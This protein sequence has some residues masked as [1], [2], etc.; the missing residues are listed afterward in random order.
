MK[1]K[2]PISA[3]D[4]NFQF[5][6]RPWIQFDSHERWMLGNLGPSVYN[7]QFTDDYIINGDIKYGLHY[8]DSEGNFLQTIESNDF[9]KDFD[10][11]RGTT[12]FAVSDLKGFYGRITTLGNYCLYG[13]RENNQ[14]ML[15]LYDLDR[16]E[17]MMTRPFQEGRA[18]MLDNSAMANYVYEPV[19]TTDNLLFT[20]DLKG[21]TLCRFPNYNPVPVMRGNAYNSPPPP[22][23]YYYAKQ[24]TIRQTLNDTVYRVIHP[25]RLLPAYVLNFGAYGTD[26]QTYF[27]G[28]LTEK[29][30]PFTWK[31]S[32]RY[33]L[34]VY[35]QNRDTPNNRRDG[36]VKFFYSYYDKKNRQLYHF[37]EDSNAPPDNEFLIENPLP[38]ALPFLLAYT[39]MEDNQL[40]VVFSKKRLEEI[41]KNKRFASLPPEQQNKLKALQNELDDGEVLI[42]ILE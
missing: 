2:H 26:V 40:R 25:N 32:E 34:I 42:M 17:R 16:N 12:S 36:S 38:D 1:L 35:T 3:T 6:W 20:L 41:V 8:F 29:L 37:N 11:A 27:G 19:N 33:I 39:D 30:L 9:P 5:D 22:D 23:I 15:C 10:A 24:L 13:I 7:F 4:G 14:Y 28:N 31:E 18:L 21:D